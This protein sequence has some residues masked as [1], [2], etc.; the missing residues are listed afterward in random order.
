M[1]APAVLAKSNC[2]VAQKIQ[3]IAAEHGFLM[4]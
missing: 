4:A 2:E 3:D 1:A